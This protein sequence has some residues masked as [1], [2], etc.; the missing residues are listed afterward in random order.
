MI[1]MRRKQLR[2]GDGL[3]A[4][5]VSD[6]REKWMTHADEAYLSDGRVV[7]ALW[8]RRSASASAAARGMCCCAGHP[9]ALCACCPNAFI[10]V[11]EGGF[12]RTL[13]VLDGGADDPARIGNEV[14]YHQHPALTQCPFGFRRARDVGALRHQLGVQPLDVAFI[15]R[16]RPC[17]RNPDVARDVDDGVAGQLLSGSVLPQ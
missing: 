14:R 8:T 1:E 12:L 2:F 15:D 7:A 16:V 4:E 11:F 9:A 6:L 10:D 3:I 13:L 17:R 5:E